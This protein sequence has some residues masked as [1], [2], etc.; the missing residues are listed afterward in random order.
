[1]KKNTSELKKKTAKELQKDIQIL[2]EEI[3]KLSLEAKANPP[4]DSNLLVKKRKILA[5]TLT[6][7][8]GI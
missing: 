2:R 6:V 3:A 5:R 1:M 8:T 4:K 7:L